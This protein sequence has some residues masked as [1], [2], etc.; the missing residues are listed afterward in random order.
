M[1]LLDGWKDWSC[2]PVLKLLQPK[3]KPRAIVL[4]DNIFRFKRALRTYVEY[5][6]SGTNGFVFD[7]RDCRRLRAIGVHG[8]VRSRAS[9]WS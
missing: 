5:V 2:L 3:L 4:A 7:A 6:Q 9:V 1:V 8:V